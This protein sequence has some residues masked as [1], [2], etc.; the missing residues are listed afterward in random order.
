MLCTYSLV[1]LILIQLHRE[2]LLPFPFYQWMPRGTLAQGHSAG[3]FQGWD[4]VL[5][6]AWLSVCALRSTSELPPAL[7][8]DGRVFLKLCS[9]FLWEG[10]P[11]PAH[12]ASSR[13]F[14]DGAHEPATVSPGWVA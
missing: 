10:V 6:A 8:C 3:G 12:P 2:I 14:S 11:G 1:Y 13:G 9:Q 7:P 5:G 4:S